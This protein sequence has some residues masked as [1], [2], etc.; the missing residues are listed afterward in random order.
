MQLIWTQ[1]ALMVVTTLYLLWRT[2]DEVRV[3]RQRTLR[4][5]VA[6]MLWVMAE[7]VEPCVTADSE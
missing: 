5:R 3:R 1:A 4:Q 7:K 2:Y 6:Y